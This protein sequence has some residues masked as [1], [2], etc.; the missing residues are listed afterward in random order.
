VKIGAH[1]WL[2]ETVY[3]LEVA[4]ARARAIG[5]DGYELDIGNFGGSGLGLQILP[6]R[7]QPEE[8]QAIRKA[9]EDA[10]I[11]MFSLCLGCLWHYPI[12]GNDDVYRVRGTEIISAAVLLAKELGAKIILMPTVQPEGVSDSQAWSNMLRSLEPCVDA[13][14][15]SGITLAIENNIQPFL[16]RASDLARM[17]DEIAS[18]SFRVYYDVANTS[19]VGI[20]PAAEIVE[21]GDRIAQFHFKNRSSLRGTPGSEVVSV[22]MPGIV[23]FEPVMRAIAEIGFDGR[24]VVEVPT[25]NKDAEFVARENY[26]ALRQLL[27]TG[28]AL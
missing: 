26:E 19:W 25:L 23:K 12:A 21:L 18:P 22:N 7:L 8:R 15:A 27:A 20:D 11:E 13:A 5:Y 17:V 28:S 1:S 3:P 14:E 4:M 6:D 2:L 16:L 10:H 9:T 24:F